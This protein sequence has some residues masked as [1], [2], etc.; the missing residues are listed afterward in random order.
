MNPERRKSIMMHCPVCEVGEVHAGSTSVSL[1]RKNYMLVINH[2]P[3]RICQSCGENYIDDET[4]AHLLR[5]AKTPAP[6][7]VNVDIR[8]YVTALTN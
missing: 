4:R 8:D 7:G 5:I 3:A 2:V 1:E 6:T